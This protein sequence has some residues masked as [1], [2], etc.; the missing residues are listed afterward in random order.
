MT[1]IE[2]Q[3]KTIEIFRQRGATLVTRISSCMHR[4]NESAKMI[5]CIRLQCASSDLNQI[6]DSSSYPL[7]LKGFLECNNQQVNNVTVMN[8]DIIS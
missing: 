7:V 1:E 2:P 5:K 4:E 3:K 8:D 6:T